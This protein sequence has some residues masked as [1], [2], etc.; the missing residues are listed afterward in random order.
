MKRIVLT[1]HLYASQKHVDLVCGFYGYDH[2]KCKKAIQQDEKLYMSFMK[3]FDPKKK[4]D[5]DDSS[6]DSDS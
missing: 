2:P 1:Q 6:D 3:Q 4:I 5:D